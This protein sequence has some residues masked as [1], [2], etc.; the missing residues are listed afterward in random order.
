MGPGEPVGH[1]VPFDIMLL[2]YRHKS[3]NK[4]KNLVVHSIEIWLEIRAC[5]NSQRES[6]FVTLEGRENYF[7]N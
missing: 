2:E 7:L 4:T 5:E 3:K 1:L 6:K